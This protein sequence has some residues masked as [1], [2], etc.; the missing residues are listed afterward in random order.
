MTMC[1]RFLCELKPKSQKLSLS[2]SHLLPSSLVLSPSPLSLTSLGM[3]SSPF[4]Y[5]KFYRLH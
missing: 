2:L 3:I 1:D 5:F 4:L